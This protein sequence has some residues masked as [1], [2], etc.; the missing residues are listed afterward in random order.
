MPRTRWPCHRASMSRTRWPSEN[1]Q[2]ACAR[3]LAQD[4]ACWARCRP[5]GGDSDG[6]LCTKGCQRRTQGGLCRRCEWCRCGST[7][8]RTD[9]PCLERC[10]PRCHP[11]ALTMRLLVC[12]LAAR[13]GSAAESGASAV[14]GEKLQ[15]NL[16]PTT[17][18]TLFEEDLEASQLAM[19][20]ADKVAKPIKSMV[21][22]S[23]SA[24]YIV[25]KMQ[26]W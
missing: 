5:D 2:A 12:T 23:Y 20:F 1:Q 14:V 16:F 15:G 13:A 7:R 6:N 11:L 9:V 19:T 22:R 25:A 18:E 10:R 26:V 17:N 24:Q 21:P 4:E 3:P 8:R